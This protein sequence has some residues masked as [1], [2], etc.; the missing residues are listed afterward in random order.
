MLKH[1]CSV[2]PLLF[3]QLQLFFVL[4]AAEVCWSVHGSPLLHSFVGLPHRSETS[5]YF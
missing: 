5:N 4:Q 2:L 1:L 3:F